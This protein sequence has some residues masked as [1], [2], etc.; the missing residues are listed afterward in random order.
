MRRTSSIWYLVFLIISIYLLRQRLGPNH[1]HLSIFQWLS[2]HRTRY[3]VLPYRTQIHC[4]CQFDEELQ[5]KRE[6]GLS[7]FKDTILYLLSL[8]HSCIEMFPLS[9]TSIHN[10]QR[11]NCGNNR[12]YTKKGTLSSP[13]LYIWAERSRQCFQKWPSDIATLSTTLC[14]Q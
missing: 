9:W 1:F 4:E 2:T 7:V 3:E 12:F 14:F 10:W 11:R 5:V 13:R 8:F 6:N